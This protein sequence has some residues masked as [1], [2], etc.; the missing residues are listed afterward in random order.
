MP[1]SMPSVGSARHVIHKAREVFTRQGLRMVTGTSSDS[2]K[3]QA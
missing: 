1:A 2:E 3:G